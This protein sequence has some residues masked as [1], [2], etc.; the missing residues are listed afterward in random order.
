MALV[1][2]GIAAMAL[3]GCPS[4]GT[5]IDLH[6][7]PPVVGLADIHDHMFADL[8]FNGSLITHDTD[9]STPCKTVP[10]YDVASMR[11]SAL[12]RQGL[13]GESSAQ[14]A[15]GQCAP[16][17]T[18]LSGQQVDVTSLKRAVDGGLRLLVIDAVNSEFLCAEAGFGPCP[19]RPSI[20]AQLQA[21]HAT[22]DRLDAEAG[23]PGRGFFRIV[24]TPAQARSVINDGKLAVVLGVEASNAWGGCFLHTD[25]TV[26][27]IPAI[28]LG[29]V[30]DE[31]VWRQTC[32]Q[33]TATMPLPGGGAATA[34]MTDGVTSLA[35]AR[36]EHFRSLGARHFFLVHNLPGQ[37]GGH[38]I[39]NQLMHGMNNP[40]QLAPGSPFDRVADMNRVVIAAR[41][42]V[43]RRACPG[44]SDFDSVT[45][46]ATGTST[47]GMCNPTGMTWTGQQLA[48]AMAGTGSLIDIDHLSLVA[49]GQL[50]GPAGIGREYP[51]VSS[52]SGFNA[53]GSG[54]ANHE[55]Q[56]SEDEMRNLIAWQGVVAPILT[57]G[58]GRGD[59]HTFPADATVVAQPCPGTSETWVQAYRYAVQRLKETPLA[60]GGPAYAGVAIGSDFNGLAGWT[61]PRF[62]GDGTVLGSGGLSEMYVGPS[63]A[64]TGGMCYPA[65]GRTFPANAPAHVAY[66]F[67]SPVTGASFDKLTMP[68]SGRTEPY[69]ISFDGVATIGM[70]PDFVEELRVLGL[71]DTDLQPLF[72]G[73]EAYLRTWEAAESYQGTW[74]TEDRRGIGD[75]CRAQRARFLDESGTVDE[76]IQRWGEALA[77]LRSS[78]CDWT[79]DT[80][81]SPSP[82]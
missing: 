46:P 39:F 77:Q 67:T 44:H 58:R 15:H 65:F 54:H 6:P 16:T 18:S 21:A 45:D 1:G 14:A 64:P 47:P 78:G 20:D 74:G 28:P 19:D 29:G 63:Q 2:T 26:P 57:Q 31:D 10:T 56:L 13:F 4:A 8:A 22:Q 12:V 43:D 53:I 80:A 48:R 9:P 30:H 25:G 62:E 51:M 61:R 38:A 11:L 42:P 5:R 68:W 82:S 34:T 66:P 71:T 32:G 3:A 69:D 23:G 49:K 55:G 72:H 50:L 41:L 7:N 75:V 17:S 33:V 70:I 37:A 81:P 36:L 35:V 24:T 27:G 60:T 73:A 59:I 40:V 76:Q 79:S 52:H